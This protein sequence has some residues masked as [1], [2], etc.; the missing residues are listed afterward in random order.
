M[1]KHHRRTFPGESTEYRQARDELL[2]AEIALRE[3][4]EHVANL[5][6]Q[7]PLGAEIKEDY[8]FQAVNPTPDHP[9]TVRL[10]ELFS[11]EKPTLLVYSFMFGPD[12]ERP[13]PA[14]S[15]LADGFNG[16]A[17]HINDATNMVIVA[18]A[19]PEKLRALASQK[20]WNRLRLLSSATNTYNVDYLAEWESE[21]GN[22]QPILNVFTRRKGKIHHFWGSE[23]LFVAFPPNHT[24]HVDMAWP[25][26]NLLDFTPEGRGTDWF[27]KLSYATDKAASKP[28][29]HS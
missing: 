13:C 27:P 5:R 17:H 19:A 10:S 26:W 11:E 16:I 15:S 1:G 20:G 28:R 12:W 6:R 9:K 18:K 3:Q 21:Y 14:C 29:C 24:R 7:L 8:E 4:I 22:Q 25:I 23:L 2:S